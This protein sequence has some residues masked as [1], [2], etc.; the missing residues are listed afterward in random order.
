MVATPGKE[1]CETMTEYLGLPLTKSV[2]AIVLAIDR[3][4]EEGKEL[5][6]K[7]VLLLVRGD[8]SLNE[9]KA[10]KVDILKGG[11]RFATDDEIMNT[12]G[13]K[14]GYLGP[15]GLSKDVPVIADLTVANMSDFVV[16]ANK[17]GYHITGVNWG[18]D[19]PEPTQVVDLRNVVEGDMSPDGKGKLTMQRGI[20]VGH[21][22]Y[23]GDRYSKPLKATFLDENG[24]PQIIHMGC[25]GIGVS[26]LLGAA[27]EQNHDDKGIIWPKAMAPFEVVICALGYDKSEAVREKADTL[28]NK[29]K[30]DGVDVILD[31]RGL[32]PGV[33]F[34]DWELI[35][36]PHRITIGDKGL[37]DGVVEYT[38]RRDM[39]TEKVSYEQVEEL[40]KEKLKY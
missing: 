17:E 28:Y 35:G 37:K 8:H 10:G 26:R 34:A 18:R 12:F 14:P 27:I 29:L 21:V 3:K 9:V 38:N 15:V 36:V 5:P 23:L 16:G 39:N 32:R 24:K 22:F 19:L 4:D 13:S 2:K 40:L 20:E 7:V 1:K 33:M 31:D 11:Y 30:A 25:Y 6:A